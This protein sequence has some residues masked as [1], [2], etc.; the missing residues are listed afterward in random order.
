MTSTGIYIGRSVAYGSASWN[1][2]ER[3]QSL[4]R[5]KDWLNA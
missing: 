2:L 1:D 4:D 3:S 5:L